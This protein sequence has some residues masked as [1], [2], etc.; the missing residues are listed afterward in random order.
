[1]NHPFARIR[2]WKSA[3]VQSTSGERADLGA[4]AEPIDTHPRRQ[5][6]LSALPGARE[7]AADKT[8]SS[9][10][11]GYPRTL[12]SDVGRTAAIGALGRLTTIFIP[13]VVMRTFG[14]GLEVDALFLAAALVLFWGISI[15]ALLETLV[16]ARF[17]SAGDGWAAVVRLG[18]A[19][20]VIGL[21][22][23]AFLIT[24]SWLIP[25]GLVDEALLSAWRWT[26]AKFTPVVLLAVWNSLLTGR[27][28]ARR[29]FGIAAASP[30]VLGLT[31][32]LSILAFAPRIGLDAVV[33]GYVVGEV[34]R[35]GWLVLGLSRSCPTDRIAP[36]AAAGF[37]LHPRVV[38]W[39]SLVLVA[40]NPVVDRVVVSSLASGH[41]SVLELVERIYQ[42]PIGLMAWAV[43]PVLTTDLA[44]RIV[45]PP[46]LQRLVSRAALVTLVAGTGLA[47]VLIAANDVVFG[48]LLG[49]ADTAW[50]ETRTWAFVWL[51]AGLPFHLAHLLLWRAALLTQRPPG[52]ILAA[53]A[54]VFALNLF[55]D[56]AVVQQF[57][58]PGVTAVTALTHGVY[59][60]CLWYVQRRNG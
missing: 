28:N 38:L 49:G 40:L 27:L 9:F 51:T 11:G 52:Q 35:L 10:W 54:G 34:F 32:L 56:V 31:V 13:V 41:I 33:L 8:T 43:L 4:T 44:A 45:R 29:Q 50:P 47:A 55:G 39:A 20:S 12:V 60:W 1:M 21:A 17:V 2:K 24:I 23:C 16:V 15:A 26:F 5:P 53:S 22:F 59:C 48:L 37:E 3:G 19:Y 58:L 18:V 6:P 42:I 25:A 36:Q 46:L 57:G 14:F 30:A 7:T